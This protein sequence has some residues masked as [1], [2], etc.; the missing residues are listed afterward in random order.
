MQNPS[1][2][3]L[4]Y[5]FLPFKRYADLKGRSRR[6]E[7][8][9]FIV[10]NIPLIAIANA[11]I[12]VSLDTVSEEYFLTLLIIWVIA[13]AAHAFIGLGLC[14][15]RLHDCGLSGHWLWVTPF[16]FIPYLG[17]LLA[18]ALMIFLFIIQFRKGDEGANRYGPSPI[19]DKLL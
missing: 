5:M 3:F 11:T 9:A 14:V 19:P 12:A 17:I 16:I 2:S 7:Y 8:W 4:H 15:R 10:I 18:I 6:L 1:P 13:G